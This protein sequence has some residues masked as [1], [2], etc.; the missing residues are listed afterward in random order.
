MRTALYEWPGIHNIGTHNGKNTHYGTI[1]SVH[2]A[3]QFA[4]N[5]RSFGVLQNIP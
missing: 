1:A 2:I 3:K 5:P 4:Q